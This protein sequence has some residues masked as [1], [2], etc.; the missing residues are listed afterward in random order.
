MISFGSWSFPQAKG[1]WSFP[2]ASLR[3]G[4]PVMAAAGVWDDLGDLVVLRPGLVQ[5][6][7]AISSDVSWSDVDGDLDDAKE[8]LFAERA[9]LKV[10]TGTSGFASR[11]ALARCVSFDAPFKYDKPRLALCTAKFELLQPHWDGVSLR[12]T[13]VSTSSF[14]VDNTISTCVTQRTLLVRIFGSLSSV[15]TLTNLHNK[16][17]FEYDG[18]SSPIPA[19]R[20]VDVHCGKMTVIENTAGGDVDRWGYFSA[21]DNQIGFMALNPGIN[22]FTQSPAQSLYLSWNWSYL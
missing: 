3:G 22:S 16:M 18:A 1:E 19:M 20:Y 14:N 15:F 8:V 5:V 12:Y 4:R 9:L 13:N 21:G 17:V 10:A 2:L 7:F 11:Q 6:K